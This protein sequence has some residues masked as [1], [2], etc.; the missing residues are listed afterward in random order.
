M[1]CQRQCEQHPG[2][3][4]ATVTY[5]APIGT[6]NC[7]GPSTTQTAGLASGATFPVGVTTNTFRVTDASGNTATCSFTVTVV[8]NQLPTITCPSNIS[9]NATSG[10]CNATVTYTAPV[11][12][13]NCSGSNTTQTTG[14]AS[15]AS[16]PA[17][18]TTNTFRVTDASGNT[19][20]C[21][22]TV[23]VVDN[24]APTITCPSNISANNAPGFCSAT[25]TY[26]TPVGSD[27]CAGSNTTQT[28]GLAS[29]SSFPVGVTTNVFRVTDASG[30]TATCSFTV[31][32]SDN[33][34]PTI[35]CPSNISVNN[36]V[37]QCAAN[38]TYSTPSGADNCPGQ[39]TSQTG[40]LASGASFPVGVTT[41][42]F[43][44][45]DAASNTATCSFTVTVTDN[46]LPVI[47]CPSNMS[48]NNTPGQCQAAV[49]YSTPSGT[50]NC[51]GQTTTQIAG[52]ASG[53]N[54]PVG[55]TTNTFRVVDA[56]GNSASCSFTVTVTDNQLPSITCPSNISTPATTG[57]CAATVTYGTPS[58]ADNCLGQTTTQTAGLASGASFPVGVTTNTF[59]VV[60]AAGNSATCSFTVTII[61]NQAPAITCP[62]NVS[63]NNTPGQCSAP[64]TYT[65]PV[66]S[67]NCS[68][69]TTIQ[70]TGLASNANFQVG[71]TTNTF[72]VT[73]ASGN[74]TTC[75]FTVTVVDNQLPTIT[76][77]SNVSV[78]NAVGQCA[79]N[80]VYST[81]SGADNCPAQ[82]TLQIAGLSSGSSFPGWR[83]HQYLPC[84][85]RQWQHGNLL[86]HGHR[87][88]QPVA[89]HH[90]PCQHHGEQH[91]RPMLRNR[92]LHHSSWC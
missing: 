52:L 13:D 23:T 73:D 88:G 66:G 6:D 78:N 14:L 40:G 36:A 42:V 19:A 59:R 74:S 7:S 70:T 10:Q 53:A 37:G 44:V 16:F 65:A 32:V 38:V 30:N 82:T 17:G 47:T 76:C 43:R 79:A 25:A 60:D 3:C 4:S 39:S 80:V 49:T 71:V 22:F 11:G 86:L 35:T 45:T 84:H 77:P 69:Q 58:G 64:V 21:A 24:Q 62:S 81:P 92:H 34:V 72:R 67:D 33:Q 5:T 12:A 85:R 27:N 20:T 50:D 26:S 63:V 75:T 90:L 9:V 61:D 31:T 8:D 87:D 56:S 68:G 41:N 46:Q 83:H 1:S 57:L 28:A 2:Q 15:G 51:T 54:F 29:G 55:V 91:P 18:V 89:D 48:V